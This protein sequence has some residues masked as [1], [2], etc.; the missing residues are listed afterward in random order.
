MD[1]KT[2]KLEKGTWRQFWFLPKACN[3]CYPRYAK[4]QL[5]SMPRALFLL[6]PSRLWKTPCAVQTLPWAGTSSYCST[7]LALC[8]G[9][10]AKKQF[11]FL[12]LQ[13]QIHI[14]KVSW[15]MLLFKM[16]NAVDQLV[17]DILPV[18]V[19]K[20]FSSQ[21]DLKFSRFWEHCIFQNASQLFCMLPLLFENA[22][23]NLDSIF[24]S[25]P[26]P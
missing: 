2:S 26:M 16:W 18:F 7:A 3:F 23:Q 17:S 14:Y 6:R 8:P 13:G 11:P 1:P 24:S 21:E 20:R 15:K 9:S 10:Y 12:R 25:A 22:V 19:R 4:M 5:P